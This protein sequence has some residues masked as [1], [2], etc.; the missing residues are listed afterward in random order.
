MNTSIKEN[1]AL[2]NLKGSKGEITLQGEA[3]IPTEWGIFS[4]KAYSDREDDLMPHLV[5][6][7]EPYQPDQV[8]NVR[9]HSECITG[10]LFGSKRCECGEQLS[11]SM[12]YLSNNGGLLIYLR[13]EGRG[14][15]IINKLHAYEKQ[16]EGYD[17]AEANSILGLEVDG[18]EYLDA[19]TILN[20]L[21][22][23]KVNLLTNNPSKLEA[24]EENGIIVES[25]IP[26]VVT[27]RAENKNYLNTKKTLFGHYLNEVI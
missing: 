14:I 1:L 23:T 21:S 25:R 17:T 12:E 10:D 13:Q 2:S 6:I 18:R 22:I 20:H 9:I 7:K 8:V 26:V 5:L 15:G 4:M 27:P 3:D 19:V 11:K 16:D 24:L